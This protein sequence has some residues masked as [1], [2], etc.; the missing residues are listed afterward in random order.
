MVERFCH[1]MPE[2]TSRVWGFFSQR[3][4]WEIL[5]LLN[6]K[7]VIGVSG[8]VLN[9]DGCVL[10]LRHRYWAG[11]LWGLPS[12]YMRK[13]ETVLEAISRE[14]MEETGLRVEVG[15]LLNI[16][17]GYRLRIG[18]TYLATI[19]GDGELILDNGEV[20]EANFFPFD[21]LP[22]GLI[23]SHREII[24]NYSISILS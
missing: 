22:E 15:Q 21:D 13:G 19:I 6:D 8:L 2:L 11:N 20:L 18:L 24:T 3:I 1:T 23:D 4:G 10:L 17:S 16:D 5:W 9:E 12:G 7:F 14:I